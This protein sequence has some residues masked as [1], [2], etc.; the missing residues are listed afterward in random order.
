MVKTRHIRWDQFEVNDDDM[1]DERRYDHPGAS[2]DKDN[3]VLFGYTDDISEYSNDISVLESRIV[4][5]TDFISRL[6]RN[7]Y[8]A[9][10]IEYRVPYSLQF[11]QNLQSIGAD[12]VT[13][14]AGRLCT[15]LYM[16]ER[17]AAIVA[18][19][20]YPHICQCKCRTMHI[21]YS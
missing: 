16:L 17:E 9:N 2:F 1:C 11:Q 14:E 12:F 3:I 18:R 20:S 13:S 19:E 4:E 8:Y 5:V 21:S 6:Q 15:K 7:Y 10:E